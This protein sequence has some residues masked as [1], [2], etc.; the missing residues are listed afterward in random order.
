MARE[1]PPRR[2][3]Q[4]H[5][6]LDAFLNGRPIQQVISGNVTLAEA[7][8]FADQLTANRSHAGSAFL[9]PVHREFYTMGFDPAVIA[10][11]PNA[12]VANSGNFSA[13]APVKEWWEL[14]NTGLRYIGGDPDSW[15]VNQWST[16]NPESSHSQTRSGLEGPGFLSLRWLSHCQAPRSFS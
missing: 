3:G 14:S 15:R 1:A 16:A 11:T 5:A 9:L 4:S 7:Q 12:V 6:A 8:W 10:L 2:S 13:P